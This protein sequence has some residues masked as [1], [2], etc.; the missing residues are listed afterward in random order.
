MSTLITRLIFYKEYLHKGLCRKGMVDPDQRTCLL[1]ASRLLRREGLDILGSHD[2]LLV[3]N[4]LADSLGHS[5]VTGNDIAAL[6][7][8]VVLCVAYDTIQQDEHFINEL[9]E[10]NDD[11]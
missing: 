6:L 2:R 4:A 1:L 8:T 3:G 11:Y 9:L 7:K 10:Q 5:D